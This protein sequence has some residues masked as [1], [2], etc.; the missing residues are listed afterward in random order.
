MSTAMIQIECDEPFLSIG[1]DKRFNLPWELLQKAAEEPAAIR[2]TM[3]GEVKWIPG[4]VV[5]DAWRIIAGYIELARL[6]RAAEGVSCYG[7]T[8]QQAT[9]GITFPMNGMNDT[10]STQPIPAP[11]VPPQG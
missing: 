11:L 9:F 3:R 5:A 7:F 8:R 2:W 1:P 4:H 6:G 10:N